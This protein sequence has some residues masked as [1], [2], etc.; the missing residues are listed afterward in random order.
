M[1]SLEQQNALRERYRQEHPG[2][3]P[4]TEVYAALVGESLPPGGRLLDLGCGRG[5]LVEQ[6]AQ[7]LERVVGADPDW[8]SLRE[9]RLGARLPR[10]AAMSE[11]LPLAGSRFDVVM[12]SWV[13]EHLPRPLLDLAE[14]RRVLRPGGRFIFL[15]PNGRHPLARAGEL[16]SRLGGA[17]ARLVERL[18]GRAPAD[19]FPAVYRANTAA[20]LR[21]LARAAGL[22]LAD[23]Q[24]IADPTYLALHTGLYRLA[25][26]LDA[27]LAVGGG[28]HLVGV[29]TK[30]ESQPEAGQAA[31]SA[32]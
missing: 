20:A 18:Y 22:R 19:T 31:L 7:P 27:A 2:W 1:L 28:I 24:A 25:V 11:A 10:V 3:R 6:L 26:G 16:L 23:L 29:M 12:A 30:P 9:H 14:V 4:A 5:G 8:R 13:L 32:R 15:T 17:Q 21:H